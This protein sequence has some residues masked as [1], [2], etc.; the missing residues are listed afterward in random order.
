MGH[1]T[2]LFFFSLLAAA[3]AACAENPRDIR[4][5]P[6][7]E[8][9]T[10][11]ELDFVR[12]TFNAVQP[13]SIIDD[14]E[15]CGF[16]GISKTGRYLATK[17]V[18]G[19]RRSCAADFPEIPDFTVLASYHTHAAHAGDLDSEVPSYRDMVADLRQ[20]VDGYVATPGGRMW[21]IDAKHKTAWM[22]C[23]RNCLVADPRYEP[24][25]RQYI[26]YAYTL[27]DLRSR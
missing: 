16:I 12:R 13:A 17:P 21:Y 19:R 1:A 9:L 24:D 2:R 5:P 27:D 20:R 3:L 18:E 14:R 26:R 25:P 8:T 11:A 7:P 15:Y 4:V 22:V 23:G 10:Q 6:R